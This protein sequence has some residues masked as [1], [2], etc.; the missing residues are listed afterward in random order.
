MTYCVAISVDAGMVF[1]SD[2]LTNAGMDQVSTYSKMYRFGRA[3]ERSFVCLTAGNLATTQAVMARLQSDI[4][5][6]AAQ[7]LLT[8]DSMQAAAEYLGNAGLEQ[9][10]KHADSGNFGASF[11][12]G[13]QIGGEPH[14]VALVYPQGNFITTSK[15][16]P[17]LQI[18]EDK[19]GKPI[20]DRI[21]KADTDLDTCALCALVSMDS[22]LRSNRSVGPPIEVLLYPAG[23]LRADNHH[24]FDED[25]AFLKRLRKDWEEALKEALRRMPPLAWADTTALA[26]ADG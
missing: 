19:Y 22:T 18:G 15:D 16:T 12:L 17:Y 7:S 5:K 23:S 6:A 4:D 13:G 26:S 9:Q 14:Q 21:V 1:C 8:V 10:R 25:S 3:G 2:S 20:L 24:R 11:I